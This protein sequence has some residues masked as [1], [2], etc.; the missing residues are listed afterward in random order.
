MKGSVFIAV[1]LDGFIARENGEID[2]LPPGGG[3]GQGEDYGYKAF[4]DTV[5]VLVMGRH[6]FETVATFDPWPYGEKP[7]VV[8]SS[9]LVTIPDRAA[10]FVETMSGSP[11]DVVEK[12]SKRGARHLYIDGGKTI[13]RFLDAG[14][15]Q[16]MTITTIPILIGKGIPLFGPLHHDVELRHL[17]TRQFSNGLIQSTYEIKS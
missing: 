3:A 4:F 6:T 9:N 13:Q 16:R 17:E 12:L 5:D 14:L 1:S 15:I 8:L 11:G 7:V 2:W 10:R